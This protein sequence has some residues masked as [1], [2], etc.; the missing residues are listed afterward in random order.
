M[1]LCAVHPI[2]LHGSPLRL[3]PQNY[4]K[5][6]TLTTVVS[7]IKSA[8]VVKHWHVI[9]KKT[10]F[11][12][13]ISSTRNNWVPRYGVSSSCCKKKPGIR[14]SRDDRGGCDAAEHKFEEPF[15]EAIFELEIMVRE[16]AEVLGGMQERL[17]AKDLELVLTYF[18]QD[19]RDSWCALEVYEWMQKENRVG[20]ETQKL[21]MAIMYEWVMKLVEGE[22]S[23]EE[24]KSLLQDM[25]CVGLKPEFHIIQTIISSYWDKGRKDKALCFVKQMLETGVESDAEDPL[26]FLLIKM[27]KAG[28]QKE[29]IELVRTL[30]GCGLEL[31][32]S[33]YSAALLAAVKEQE[34][35]TKVQREV[36][37]LVQNGQLQELEKHEKEAFAT[38]EYLL[39][40]QAEEIVLW[41]EKIG[42]P[43]KLPVIYE[44]LL[45]MYCIAGNG[46]A[47]ERAL[48]QMKF[49][50]RE[51]PVEM[52]N[53]V[54]GVCGFGNH[55]EAAFRVLSRME[56]LGLMPVKKTYTVLIGG[57]LKGGNFQEASEALLLMLTKGLRPDF[58]VMLAVLRSLQKAG[59]VSQYLHLCKTLADVGI[60]EP[61]LVY[62]YIDTHNLCIIRV[63]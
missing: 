34:Q 23:V 53:T 30:H 45:A 58:H 12:V 31:R 37:M 52:Y 61:C 41:A 29:A 28:E 14:C 40:L 59:R 13:N 19:G 22:Q 16:P 10:E 42:T 21:M 33:S 43:D 56:A 11:C 4:E 6:A 24:V 2:A 27:V 36:R 54:V 49:S 32:I 35:F 46:L 20:D 9:P 51:P 47:A 48:W 38:Y 25:Y 18:A 63:L 8:R 17:S 3:C 44:R 5:S 1:A 26:A 50:G 39:H 62:V 7:A 55:R 15:K 60:I 57:F